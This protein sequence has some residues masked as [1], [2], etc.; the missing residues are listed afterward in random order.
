MAKQGG[1]VGPLKA[2]TDA[3]TGLSYIFTHVVM[4]I[5]AMCVNINKL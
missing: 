2:A 1:H 4:S 3:L 5:V